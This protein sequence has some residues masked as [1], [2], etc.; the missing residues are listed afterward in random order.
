MRI[1]ILEES[2][3]L[4][5]DEFMQLLGGLIGQM[6]QQGDQ[7]EL[8]DQLKELNREV[9]RFTMKRNLQSS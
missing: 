6:E 3:D 1:K 5:N 2:G 4:V 9:L 8:L 7:P